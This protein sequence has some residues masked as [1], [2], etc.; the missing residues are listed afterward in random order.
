MTLPA[1]FVTNDDGVESE[2]LRVL[3]SA[4]HSRGYPAV[5]LA[6]ATE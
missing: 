4:I 6:P 5:V 3:V 1:V 2:G